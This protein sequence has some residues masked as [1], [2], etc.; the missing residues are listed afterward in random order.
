VAP[1]SEKSD[2]TDDDPHIMTAGPP[3]ICGPSEKGFTAYS[4]VGTYHAQGKQEGD[5]PS[6]T[7]DRER[8]TKVP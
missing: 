4:L 3:L 5:T 8:D 7:N 2:L 6:D 1:K